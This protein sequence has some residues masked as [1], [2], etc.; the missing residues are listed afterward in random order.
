MFKFNMRKKTFFIFLF[1]IEAKTFDNNSKSL[2]FPD[3]AF[4]LIFIL[5]LEID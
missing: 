4:P 2:E 5:I 3:I 1:F